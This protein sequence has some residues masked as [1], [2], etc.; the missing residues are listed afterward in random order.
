MSWRELGIGALKHA[1]CAWGRAL[2]ASAS[3]IRAAGLFQC[4][5]ALIA[6]LLPSRRGGRRRR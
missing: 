3:I 6:F 2:A 4:L 5:A 1:V